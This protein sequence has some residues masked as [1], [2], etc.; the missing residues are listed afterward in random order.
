MDDPKME[1]NRE[2]GLK[3]APT[4]RLRMVFGLTLM[5]ACLLGQAEAAAQTAKWIWSPKVGAVTAGESQGDCYFRN[6]FTLIK[7]EKAEVIYSVGDEFELYINNQL[8]SKGESYGSESKLDV[9]SYMKPGVNLIAM[10][11]THRGSDQPGVALKVRIKEHDETRWRSL[12]TNNTWK[13]RNQLVTGWTQNGYNDLCLLYTS[14]SPRDKRQS[15]MPS[16]A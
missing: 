13:T 8:V 4:G 3:I 7:P 16:S 1:L 6:K 14:P 10:K 9:F 5:F 12:V 15:R 2:T 11:V